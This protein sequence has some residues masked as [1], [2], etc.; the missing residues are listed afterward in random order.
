MFGKAVAVVM[1]TGSLGCDKRASGEP[2]VVRTSLIGTPTALF[3]LFGDRDDPRLLPVAMAAKG[4]I[5]PI[6]LDSAGWR[7]FDRVYFAP[8]AAFSLYHDGVALKEGAIRRG[9]WSQSDPLYKLPGCR[10]LRPL[11]AA[12]IG[13][14]P[15]GGQTLELLATSRPLVAPAP[16]AA[17]TPA[18]LDSARAFAGR[19]AQRAGLTRIARDELELVVYAIQTGATERPTLVGSYSE[20]GGGAGPGARHVFAIGDAALEGYAPTYV[21]SARDSVPEFRRLIGHLDLTGDGLDELVLEG[22]RSGGE[23]FLVIMQ[24]VGGRWHEVARGANSWCA[25]ALPSTRG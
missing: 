17:V 25:D 18:D 20:K 3:L 22:W 21:H 13:E 23:S 1:L 15:N 10:S 16:R 5:A 8:A 11:A 9:M 2:A 14:V 12:T 4:R 6:S 24:F 19:A 7:E